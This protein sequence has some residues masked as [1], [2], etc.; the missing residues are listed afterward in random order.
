MTNGNHHI[1]VMMMMTVMSFYARAKFD[2]PSS[3]TIFVYN[4]I[5]PM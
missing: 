4:L 5:H 3:I 1:Q 2:G